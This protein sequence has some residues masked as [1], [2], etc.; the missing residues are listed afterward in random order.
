M[1]LASN[2]LAIDR[3]SDVSSCVEVKC[4]N[5]HFVAQHATSY[6]M[7]HRFPPTIMSLTDG[8]VDFPVVRLETWCGEFKVSSVAHN[9]K[10]E[11]ILK[12]PPKHYPWATGP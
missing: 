7:C 9:A 3:S 2:Q 5:C 8:L 11:E 12:N 4:G 10:Y 6:G 1:S